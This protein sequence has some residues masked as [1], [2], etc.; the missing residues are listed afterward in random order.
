MPTRDFSLRRIYL[1]AVKMILDFTVSLALIILLFPLLLLF[2]LVLLVHFQR[3]PFFIQKR[4][5]KGG[6]TFPLIKFRTLGVDGDHQSVSRFGKILRVTSV[7]ELPQLI[8][9]LR[10]EM[11]FVGP[12][13]LLPEYQEFYTI[14]EK[15]RHSV[16]PGLTGLTQLTFGNSPDWDK[17]MNS[18]IYYVE[19][20]S[21]WVD[22]KLLLQTV[23]VLFNFKKKSNLDKEIERFDDFAK[24]R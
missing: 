24:H 19:K 22:L 6:S 1:S 16:K 9:I 18:D 12:R 17:R 21:F 4:I 8:N 3:S 15:R 20:V 2:S 10:G 23:F 7:D 11:S 5:G 13:P 14:D